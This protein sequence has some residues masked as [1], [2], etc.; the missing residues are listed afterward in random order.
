M[1]ES[2]Y[3]ITKT[4]LFEYIQKILSPKNENFRIKN[5]Y[6]FQ[7]SVQNIDCWYSLEP[8]LTSTHN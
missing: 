7:I 5:S 1:G 8:P 4:S 2:T 6:I 3:F